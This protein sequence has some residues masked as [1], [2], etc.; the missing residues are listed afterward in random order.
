LLITRFVDPDA[1]KRYGYM[2]VYVRCT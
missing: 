2:M 1:A